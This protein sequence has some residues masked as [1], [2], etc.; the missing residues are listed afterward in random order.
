MAYRVDIVK[1]A[2]DET[3][4]KSAY[5]GSGFDCGRG[6]GT[7]RINKASQEITI[8]A[9]GGEDPA[10]KVAERGVWAALKRWRDDDAYPE[11]AQWA[12]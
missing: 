8:S 10:K 9:Q 7:F 6:E 1:Q 4:V 5:S 12:S 2:E 3:A 11:R